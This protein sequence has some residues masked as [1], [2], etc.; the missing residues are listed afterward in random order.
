MWLS[1][2]HERAWTLGGIMDHLQI[3]GNKLQMFPRGCTRGG[4]VC[5]INNV[6]RV[7]QT[8]DELEVSCLYISSKLSDQMVT[9]MEQQQ[10][11]KLVIRS[12]QAHPKV[13]EK[14]L[15]MEQTATTTTDDDY[16]SDR[17]HQNPSPPQRR[18][19]VTH[20]EIHKTSKLDVNCMK[21]ICRLSNLQS[22]TLNVVP[23]HLE[24]LFPLLS[25]LESLHT[26][27]LCGCP[28]ERNEQCVE[29]C[30]RYLSA[31]NN[32]CHQYEQRQQQQ[33]NPPTSPRLRN[34]S[35]KCCRLS[36]GAAQRL[37]GA[38]RRMKYLEKLDLVG[39]GTGHLGLD[40]LGRLLS[41]PWVEELVVLDVSYQTGDL[42]DV[43][44]F[45][46]ALQY[47]KTLKVLRLAGNSL[48]NA[49]VQLLAR[50]LAK[51]TSLND[52]DLS[53]N[54]VGD[55]GLEAL[56]QTME[57]NQALTTLSLK[58]NA[59]ADLSCLEAVLRSH[60]YSLQRLHHS[61]K[62]RSP[63][64]TTTADGSRS[65]ATVMVSG[66]ERISYYLRLNQGGRI[67]LKKDENCTPLGLWPMVLERNS[68]FPTGNF[69]AIFFLLRHSSILFAAGTNM[70]T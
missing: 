28:L 6:G 60:N 16:K 63:S 30:E 1:F 39:N 26:L 31:S 57:Q 44:T 18:N 43:S 23:Y 27:S 9:L 8:I 21:A 48:G 29:A 52:L 62:V 33:Q 54:S 64:M 37:V 41:S 67:L 25:N 50:A 55:R 35:F 40:A 7:L 56:I 51:N 4:N 11:R 17:E 53:A 68:N 14:L 3:R 20:L 38:M 58:Y 19:L 34:L 5:H 32:N 12:C 2:P 45:A 46:N 47:N 42:G 65:T 61:C 13:M 69:D 24:S 36:D 66:G 49:N 15:L 22:L 70:M 10:I 59:F